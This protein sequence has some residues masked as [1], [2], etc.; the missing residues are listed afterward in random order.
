MSDD[1]T[2]LFGQFIP[3]YVKINLNIL[4]IWKIGAQCVNFDIVI[5]LA[6]CVFCMRKIQVKFPQYCNHFCG[7]KRSGLRKRTSAFQIIVITTAD[8]G[9]TQQNT[10]SAI[11]TIVIPLSVKQLKLAS[12]RDQ[13]FWNMPWLT[14]I[15]II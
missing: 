12:I 4:L 11:R 8:C 7:Q 14:N 1:S 6:F 13:P 2:N 15:E 5:T 10:Q 3:I 9:K